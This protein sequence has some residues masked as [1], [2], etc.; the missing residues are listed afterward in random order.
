[1]T[2]HTAIS[3]SRP[4]LS[5][6]ETEPTDGWRWPVDID[7]YDRSVDL[8]PAERAAFDVLDT[9]AAGWWFRPARADARRGAAWL[10]LE[11]LLAPLRAAR[12][13]LDLPS[14][15]HAIAANL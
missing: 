2:V 8:T 13:A 11:R 6:A 3:P 9:E 5:I 14:R 15:P 10:M 1:M 7:R 12:N 4:S